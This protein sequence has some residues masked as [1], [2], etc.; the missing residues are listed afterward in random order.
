MMSSRNKIIRGAD[1]EGVVFCTPEGGVDTEDPA[2]RRDKDSLKTLEEF[3]H[4][5][6]LAEGRKVGFEEGYQR[7]HEEGRTKGLEEGSK[8][9]FAQGQE[10]GLL[11]GR[12]EGEEKVRKELHD[13]LSVMEECQKKLQEQ[14]E[15]LYEEA[16]PE[17]VKFALAVCERVIRCRLEDGDKWTQMVQMLLQQARPILHDVVADVV[18][19]SEDLR[20]LQ[21]AID[22]S[23]FE[24]GGAKKINF[25][26][27][28]AMKRGDCR[29]E[30]PMGLLNFDMKRILSDLEKKTLE[31]RAEEG[32]HEKAP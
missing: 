9:G 16:K 10:K 11:Q 17:L 30:T 4:R 14:Q 2:E 18:V 5:K 3:W 15:V 12:Q 21:D 23:Y 8:T 31:V 24:H 22:K 32:Q 19:S 7:G 25:V 1:V 27:D 20:N 13:S 26:A 6:G 28:D 29:I